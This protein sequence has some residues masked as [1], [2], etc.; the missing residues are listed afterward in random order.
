ME[1]AEATVSEV[2]DS[3]TEIVQSKERKKRV[4]KKTTEPQEFCLSLTLVSLKSQK[5]KGK[6]LVQKNIFEEITVFR[7]VLYL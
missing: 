4:K 5:E 6:R 3:S 2:D 1:I 7:K